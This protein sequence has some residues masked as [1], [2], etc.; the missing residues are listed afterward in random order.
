[1]YLGGLP[2]LTLVCMPCPRN[3]PIDGLWSCGIERVSKV[4]RK[5]STGWYLCGSA[6]CAGNIG[7]LHLEYF[8][9]GRALI[10]G[11]AVLFSVV[12]VRKSQK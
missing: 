1:M 4:F 5:K 6:Y 12:K 11:N 2:A 3:C 7:V 10:T 8:E 9:V